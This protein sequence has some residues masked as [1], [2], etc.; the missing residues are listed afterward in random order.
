MRKTININKDWRFVK[1]DLNFERAVETIGETIDVPFTWNNIDGQ[2][3]GN[4]YVRA[5]YVF[6][7]KF[8]RP[9]HSDS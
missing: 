9:E 7:K 3:G 2:D 5:A 4:D 8:F 6:R 1:E